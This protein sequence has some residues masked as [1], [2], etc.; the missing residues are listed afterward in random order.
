MEGASWVCALELE[1][2][3]QW[4]ADLCWMEQSVPSIT[5]ALG[6]GLGVPVGE[7]GHFG[8]SLRG[9]EAELGA[10]GQ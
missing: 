9:K 2:P 1:G 6:R 7:H 10:A 3:R 5:G 8:G 4:R